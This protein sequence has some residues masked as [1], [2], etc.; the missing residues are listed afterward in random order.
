MKT[1]PLCVSVGWWR[2]SFPGVSIRKGFVRHGQRD[3]LRA[4]ERAQSRRVPGLDGAKTLSV[5]LQAHQANASSKCSV[6]ED[7][8]RD[9]L[10]SGRRRHGYIFSL[11][12]RG[13]RRSLSFGSPRQ[14]P[15]S[16]AVLGSE[17]QEHAGGRFC[18]FEVAR[19]VSVRRHRKLRV[20]EVLRGE[21]AVEAEV[22]L[23]GHVLHQ[24]L[25]STMVRSVPRRDSTPAA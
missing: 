17:L 20:G 15:G 13:C 23:R 11:A 19:E 5:F 2:I 6:K 12:R 9:R 1:S 7:L 8:H 21:R 22:G 4:G 18:G 3:A 24:P 25:E 16:F 14:R 10:R